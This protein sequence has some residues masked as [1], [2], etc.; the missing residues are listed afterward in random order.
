MSAAKRV[1]TAAGVIR[2][3]WER[4]VA[5]DP[6]TTAAQ[7]LEDA[8]LLMSPEIAAELVA[9]RG[10]VA[11]LER[12]TRAAG[13]CASCGDLPTEWC[14]DCASCRRGCFGDHEDYPCVHANASWAG[15]S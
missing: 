11:E 9:L 1:S 2:A 12:Q 8:G 14:P 7:A 3:A 5:G 10:R 13:A 4:G 15:A 6:Q